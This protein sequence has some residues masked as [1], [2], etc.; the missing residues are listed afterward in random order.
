MAFNSILSTELNLCEF[1]GNSYSE[2]L[3]QRLHNKQ[4]TAI[5][6]HRTFFVSP[7]TTTKKFREKTCENSSFFPVHPGILVLVQIYSETNRHI[8]FSCNQIGA[9]VAPKKS[10]YR[11]TSGARTNIDGSRPLLYKSFQLIDMEWQ[12]SEL[13]VRS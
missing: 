5:R 12:G 10:V 11:N 6:M 9:G 7:G 13:V 8:K 2:S 3:L 4:T 1:S